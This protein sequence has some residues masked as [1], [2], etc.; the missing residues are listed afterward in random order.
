[1]KH[2][3]NLGKYWDGAISVAIYAPGTDYYAALEEIA[4]L[5][6]CH[7]N[8]SS[9]IRRL[10]SF[11]LIIPENHLPDNILTASEVLNMQ[12]NCDQKLL[13]IDIDPVPMFCTIMFTSA[14]QFI[15]FCN[16]NF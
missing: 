5:R 3:V 14:L 2:L 4:Y 9:K 15:P 6:H 12:P 16:N 7:Y 8:V 1:M 11:T 10:M 13:V